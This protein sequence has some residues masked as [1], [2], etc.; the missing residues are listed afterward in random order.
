MYNTLL[1]I[2]SPLHTKQNECVHNIPVVTEK[3]E[4]LVLH[5]ASSPTS[6]GAWYVQS[7]Y[8]Y[9]LNKKNILTVK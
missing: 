9:F 2:K 4:I 6:K 7:H 3:S 8:H 5:S 1:I